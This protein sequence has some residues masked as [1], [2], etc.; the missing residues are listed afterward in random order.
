MAVVHYVTSETLLPGGEKL[1]RGKLTLS[2]YAAGGATLNLANYLKD[3]Q[4][5]TVFVG[6]VANATNVAFPT[7]VNTSN[8]ESI[9]ILCMA[10]GLGA[11]Q[12]LYFLN[13]GFELTAQNVDFYALGRSY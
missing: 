6:T 5:P 2:S 10:G 12:P 8:A 13:A 4:V 3:D 7:M 9:K 1:I 11:S